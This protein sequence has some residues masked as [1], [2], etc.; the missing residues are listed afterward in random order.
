[1]LRG[2]L[3]AITLLEM[4]AAGAAIGGITGSNAGIPPPSGALQGVLAYSVPTASTPAL[5]FAVVG[6]RVLTGRSRPN[7]LGSGGA[8]LLKD[9]WDVGFACS[10]SFG[11]G[12]M[13]APWSPKGNGSARFECSDGSH[14]QA[15]FHNISDDAGVGRGS[16][17]DGGHVSLCYGF[18]AKSA[19]RHLVAPSGYVL[20]VEHNQLSLRPSRL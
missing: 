10:G 18:P 1:M 17:D 15:S 14:F 7:A 4:S 11:Y 2:F 5:F 8:V 9:E 12:P 16:G 3:I 19:A 6:K 20:V 13:P